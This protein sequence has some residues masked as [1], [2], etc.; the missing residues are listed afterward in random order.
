MN[1]CSYLI[2]SFQNF[3]EEILIHNFLGIEISLKRSFVCTLGMV[4]KPLWKYSTCTLQL[5]LCSFESISF[6]HYNYCWQPLLKQGILRYS[7]CWGP[8]WKHSTYT[9]QLLLRPLWKFATYTLKLLLGVSLKARIFTSQILLGPLWNQGTYTLQLLLGAT[10]KA[11]HLHTTV[12]FRGPFDEVQQQSTYT[13]QLLLGAP[14][15][16][17]YLHITISV[18]ALWK[19]STCFC[20]AS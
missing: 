2:G 19:Q 12:S 14:L 6:T 4:V 5:L 9:L 18:G 20:S 17:K 15:K 7:Y 8:L 13:F 16:T 1:I 11:E 10:V 3:L